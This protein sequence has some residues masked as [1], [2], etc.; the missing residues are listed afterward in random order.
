M[1]APLILLLGLLAGVAPEAGSTAADEVTLRDGKVVLGQVVEEGTRGPLVMIVR[2]SWA[3][4]ALPERAKGWEAEETPLLER[5]RKAR[6]ARLQAWRRERA[7]GTADRVDR[8]LDEEIAR[9]EG[10][11]GAERPPLMR[12]S[13]SRREVRRVVRRPKWATRLLLLGWKAGVEGVESMPRD[14]LR[15]ALAGRGIAP[16]DR[17]PVTVDDLLLRPSESEASWRLRRA[18]TEVAQEPGLW[19]VRAH[20][21]V[22]PEGDPHGPGAAAF[23][24]TDLVNGLAGAPGGDPLAA[25]AREVA[26]RGR[27][28]LVVTGMETAPD[29]SSVQV[30]ATL[31]VRTGPDRWEPAISRRATVRPGDLPPDAGAPLAADPQVDAAFR[32]VEGLGLGEVSGEMKRVA[33]NVGAA[34]RRAN[35]LAR[36]ALGREIDAMAISLERGGPPEPG[37]GP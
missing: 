22:L 29:L 36:S 19:F 18:A 24:L 11:G 25:R 27:I 13:L 3:A 17:S 8:R 6:R 15:E 33:L 28:G 2:R 34:V 35:G 26:A 20:G 5:A 31:W 14:A 7:A 16:N 23:A 21:L 37:R 1:T 10:P 9:L 32:L 4:E 12:V 30:E